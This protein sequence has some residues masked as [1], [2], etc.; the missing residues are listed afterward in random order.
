MMRRERKRNF[1]KSNEI[2][3]VITKIKE[4]DGIVADLSNRINRRQSFYKKV[5]F[6]FNNLKH[7]VKITTLS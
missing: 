6:V 5:I 2:G 1:Y 3:F 7:F 4:Y